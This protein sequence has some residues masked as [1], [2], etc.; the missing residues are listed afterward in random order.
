MQSG[1]MRKF[2]NAIDVAGI[3]NWE[4]VVDTPTHFYNNGVNRFNIYD[5]DEEVVYNFGPSIGQSSPYAVGQIVV[6]AADIA[7]IHEVVIG[8]TVEEINRFATAY[9]FTFTEDQIKILYKIQG[10]T[11]DLKPSTG[12]YR[13][14]GFRVLTD[15]EVASLTKDQKE[16]Y[17]ATLADYKKYLKEKESFKGVAQITV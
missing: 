13:F 3:K 5:E 6:K 11:H 9:G 7:D 1:N 2:L 17:D 16:L 12:D 14:A 4:A 10:N 15:E 8:G